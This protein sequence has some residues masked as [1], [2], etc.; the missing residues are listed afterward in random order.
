MF[1]C[2][3]KCI[4]KIGMWNNLKGKESACRPC[5]ENCVYEVWDVGCGWGV[6]RLLVKVSI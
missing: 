5:W 2:Q 6:D 3:W 4:Q 1:G